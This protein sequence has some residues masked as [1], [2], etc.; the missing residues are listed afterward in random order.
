MKEHITEK[1]CKIDAIFLSNGYNSNAS[2]DPFRI[3]LD[4]IYSFRERFI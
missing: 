4:L 2:D 3:I 1:P